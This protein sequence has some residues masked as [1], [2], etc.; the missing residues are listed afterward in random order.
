MK[1][2]KT[3]GVR[4]RRNASK[5][6]YSVWENLVTTRLDLGDPV[7]LE[8]G[9]SEF[10]D[11]GVNSVC[12][13]KCPFCF[14]PGTEVNTP[15]GMKKIEDLKLADEIYSYNVSSGKV[16]VQGVSQTHVRQILMGDFIRIELPSGKHIDSTL[17]HKFYTKNRGWIDA[18]N[19]TPDDILMGID[20]EDIHIVSSQNIMFAYM[21]FYNLGEEV[22][23][24][25]FVEG[26]LVHNCYVSADNTG[27]NWDN[28]SDTWKRF[29]D[30]LPPDEPITDPMADPVLADIL[31]KPEPETTAEELVFKLKTALMLRKHGGTYTHKPLQIAIGE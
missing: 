2:F 26:V 30:T 14:F 9:C 4:I 6:Y 25:Y 17:N 22:N 28:P 16:E 31:S 13:L 12:N 7:P 11:V 5:N 3:W 1:D 15:E 29:I 19:I 10:Y 27:K 24:N 21:P 8:P 20:G 23:N 18:A